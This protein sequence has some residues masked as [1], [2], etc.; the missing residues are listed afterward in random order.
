M[1]E[2]TIKPNS[3]QQINK[4]ICIGRNYVE[5]AKELNSEVPQSPIFFLKPT[6]SVCFSYDNI[7]YPSFTKN[8]HHEVELVIAIGKTIKN[9]SIEEAN[10]AILAYAVGLDMTAR[11]VQNDY[12]NKGLPWALSKCFDT[13]CVLSTFV[14]ATDYKPTLNEKILLYVNNTECQNSVLNQMIFR[15]LELIKYLSTVMTLEPGDLIMTGTPAGVGPVKIGDT[16]YAK[17]ENIGEIHTQIT[18]EI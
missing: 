9:A 14:S 2:I 10:G 7:V 16:I 15:P 11:D 4:I 1:K 8:L 3:R 6:S 5:H 12:I 18:E 17:I 13:S